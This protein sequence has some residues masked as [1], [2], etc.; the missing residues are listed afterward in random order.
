MIKLAKYAMIAAIAL[1]MGAC[2]SIQLAP[3]GAYQAGSYSVNLGSDWNAIPIK[4]GKRKKA[5]LLTKD[6]QLLNAV[7]LFS[8]LEAG[9]S[10][11]RERRKENPVPKFDTDLSDLE[12]VEF[13]VDSLVKA[14]AYAGVATQNVRPDSFNGEDAIRFELSGNTKAGLN[15]EGSALMSVID[16]K[17]NIILFMAPSEYYA[18]KD[19]ADIDGI[20]NS[21]AAGRGIG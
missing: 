4:T 10:L 20:F 11:L 15:V 12:L 9:D 13:L 7:Y 17:L 5:S 19:R 16:E 6:G 3:A 2:A 18:S 8:D 21:V 1:S 14:G